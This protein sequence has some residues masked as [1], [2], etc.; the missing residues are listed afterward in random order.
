[1]FFWKKTIQN[2]IVGIFIFLPLSLLNS[3]HAEN[4]E[5]EFSLSVSNQNTYFNFP[6]N[7]NEVRFDQLGVSWYESFSSYFH[8]GLEL[9]YIEMSQIYIRSIYLRRICWTTVSFFTY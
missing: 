8:A 6:S 2:C 4:D 9:G 1:M 3:A 5:F 7:T